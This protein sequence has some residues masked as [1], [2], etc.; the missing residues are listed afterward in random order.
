MFQT[1][2]DT[3]SVTSPILSTSTEEINDK[4]EFKN[5]GYVMKPL[6]RVFYTMLFL[7]VCSL[8]ELSVLSLLFRSSLHFS[9]P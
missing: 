2:R 8:L 9:T 7:S 6:F 5:S 4:V 3:I 1:S